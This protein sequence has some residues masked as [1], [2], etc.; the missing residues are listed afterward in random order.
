MDKKSFK[1]KFPNLYREIEG[2]ENKVAINSY[3]TDGEASEEASCD[4][5]RNFNPTVIDFI[6]RCDTEEEAKT[7]ILFLEKR[8]E[9]TS[10]RAAQLREQLKTKGVRSFGSKK[11]NNYYLKQGGY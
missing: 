8:K 9:I 1:E 6:R 3:R 5:L 2:G 4:K 7:I 11:E 10:K